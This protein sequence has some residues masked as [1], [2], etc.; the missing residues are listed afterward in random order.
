MTGCTHTGCAGVEAPLQG[1]AVLEEGGVDVVVVGAGSADDCGALD[2]GPPPMV[3]DEG[4]G[5]CDVGVVPHDE[6]L[7]ISTVPLLT[8]ATPRAPEIKTIGGMFAADGK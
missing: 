4:V 3:V 2:V 5:S 6:L 8:I 7:Q 1:N